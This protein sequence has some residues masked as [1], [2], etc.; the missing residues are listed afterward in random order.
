MRFFIRKDSYFN[1]QKFNFGFHGFHGCLV[2][3]CVG[4]SG[5]LTISWKQEVDLKVICYSSSVIHSRIRDNNSG[6]ERLLS[7][8]YGPVETER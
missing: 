5:S 1:T 6:N 8:N 2:V 7:G 3:D 4:R